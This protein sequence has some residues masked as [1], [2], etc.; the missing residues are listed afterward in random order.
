MY[1]AAGDADSLFHVVIHSW[2]KRMGILLDRT[3]S[4]HKAGTRAG[5]GVTGSQVKR[6]T[7]FE[8]QDMFVPLYGSSLLVRIKSPVICM[9]DCPK[10]SSVIWPNG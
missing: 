10:R 4:R 2:C 5:R 6:T 1:K 7:T 9:K 8:L 3:R